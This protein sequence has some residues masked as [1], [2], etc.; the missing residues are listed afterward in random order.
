M[1]I[2]R[3]INLMY[4]ISLLQ[5]MI[6]YGPIATLYRQAA[7][8]SIFQI[9]I[10]ES[11][12]LALCVVLELP[13]GIVA[14]KIGYK[15]TMI[16]C[17]SLY[18]ISKIVFWKAASFPTFLLERLMLSIIIA[19]MSGVDT[20]ILY[21]SCSNERSQNIFATYNNLNTIGLL[22]AA[23]TYAFFIKDRYRLASLLTVFSY[24]V[25][26][27][28][29]LFLKEVRS[30]QFNRQRSPIME[31]RSLFRA[32]IKN[33]PLLLFLI[34]I[35][36]LNETHQTVT[37]FLNQLQYVKCGLSSATIGCIYILVTIL[38]LLGGLSGWLTKQLGS[39]LLG[40]L[41]FAFCIVAC[42]MLALSRGAL[43]SMLA[44]IM[45]RI[46]F[47]LF[48]PLQLMLQNK[49]IASSNRATALSINAA[50]IDGVAIATNVV[51][52][53]LAEINLTYAM[54]L[55][56]GF[57]SLG[58]LLFTIWNQRAMPSSFC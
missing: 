21:L 13:W 24:G 23:G 2:K 14:D 58:L 45:L 26:A 39:T 11:I 22:V 51:F 48:Q 17:C 35:A 41:L 7:G 19:G 52:G 46:S 40:S 27:L 36:L 12:S 43:F 16:F 10:I 18:F 44:I 6:F 28:L 47:S 33:K 49:Q 34:S 15:K 37:V 30:T 9:T 29:T 25:A 42:V 3:N 1:Q 57:C 20:S 50:M 31:F 56:A 53:K 32:L 5:G 38:G 4:A 55:G 8:I 54:V